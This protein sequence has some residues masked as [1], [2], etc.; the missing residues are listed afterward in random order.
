MYR[1]HMWIIGSGSKE[2]L[3]GTEKLT[4]TGHW[5]IPRKIIE[6]V[7][8][9]RKTL[10]NRIRSQPDLTKFKTWV[11]SLPYVVSCYYRIKKVLTPKGDWLKFLKKTCAEC[12]NYPSMGKFWK[13][14]I[15]LTGTGANRFRKEELRP[16][17]F[18][19]QKVPQK[20]IGTR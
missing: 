3:K 8:I 4:P 5:R 9:K 19:Y 7:S 15:C 20:R 12:Y 14:N 6:C 18:T 10:W 17:L 16:I 11:S 2:N 1:Y 13:V